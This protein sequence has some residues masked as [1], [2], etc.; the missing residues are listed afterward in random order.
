VQDIWFVAVYRSFSSFA[1]NFLKHGRFCGALDGSARPSGGRW[2]L[3]DLPAALSTD[4]RTVY[5]QSVSHTGMLIK[6]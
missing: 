2:S 6:P 4:L 3:S 1:N 5:V